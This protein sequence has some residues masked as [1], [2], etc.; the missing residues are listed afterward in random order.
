MQEYLCNKVSVD[1]FP[2]TEKFIKSKKDGTT[3]SPKE[4]AKKIITFIK[5]FKRDPFK[6]RRCI[7]C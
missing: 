6:K 4:T 3:M 1:D 5:K 7:T 2:V